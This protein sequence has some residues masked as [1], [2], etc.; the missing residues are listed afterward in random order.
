MLWR[1]D[2]LGDTEPS[3]VRFA[4]DALLKGE[5]SRARKNLDNA[6]PGPPSIGARLRLTLEHEHAI[7]VRWSSGPED[8]QADM[9]AVLRE[10]ASLRAEHELGAAYIAALN[11]S[12]RF[13]SRLVEVDRN[14]ADR[15][16]RSVALALVE[17]VRGIYDDTDGPE[18]LPTLTALDALAPA[19]REAVLDC[20]R[21][22]E[23]RTAR[24]LLER[25]RGLL[26]PG[27]R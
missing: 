27:E 20:V 8:Y 16:A 15:G 26:T 4:V 5:E 10:L 19:L 17:G 9:D 24:Q 3:S 6:L 7:R 21:R 18:D 13:A 1:L 11:D 2:M 25:V 12:G 22:I 14:G 23:E